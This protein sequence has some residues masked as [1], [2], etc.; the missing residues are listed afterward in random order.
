MIEQVI[1]YFKAFA[2]SHI[3]VKHSA[4]NKA[5][6]GMDDELKSAVDAKTNIRNTAVKIEPIT[7]I[8]KSQG[9]YT[10]EMFNITLLIL[11][12]PGPNGNTV[13]E[14]EILSDTYETATDFIGKIHHDME[15]GACPKLFLGFNRDN[16]RTKFITLHGLIG[17]QLD[18]KVQGNRDISYNAEKWQ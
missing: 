18:I 16:C 6:F 13:A 11:K 17:T 8:P 1:A 2:E 3:R 12:K 7:M 14:N 9:S 10:S 15:N 5:F 4:V